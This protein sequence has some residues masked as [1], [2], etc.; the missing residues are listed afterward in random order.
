M[1]NKKIVAIVFLL[2][3]SFSIMSPIMVYADDGNSKDP[4]YVNIFIVLFDNILSPFFGISEPADHVFKSHLN[5]DENRENCQ[6]KYWGIYDYEEFNN[7]IF[8]GYTI[9]SVVIGSLFVGAL[10]KTFIQFS[11][12]PLSSTLKLNVIDV[13]LRTFIALLLILNFFAIIGMLFEL[14]A[15]G[16]SLLDR[17]I[18]M[19][20]NLSAYGADLVGS[21]T[22]AGDRITVTDLAN[23][24]N[25]FKRLI[26]NFF[27]L[28]IA[29]WFEAF[30]LM[31]I[32][33]ISMLIILAPIWIGTMFFPMLKGITGAAMKE[34]WAQIISQF[35]HAALFWLFFWLF[36]SK[37][38]SWF[39]MVLALAMFIPIAEAIRFVLGATSQNAGRIATVATLAGAGALFHG[40]RA[41]KDVSS[42]IKEG[43]SMMR[44]SRNG[45]GH[46][47]EG[48][49]RNSAQGGAMSQRHRQSA[50]YSMQQVQP[51]NAHQNKMQA[52]GAMV[53]GLGR[54]LGRFGG[55][56]SGIG[57]GPMGQY[58]M[59]EMGAGAGDAAGY[60][61]GTAAYGVG[62]RAASKT[63]DAYE[64]RKQGNDNMKFMQKVRAGMASGV[65][66]AKRT[67]APSKQFFSDPVYRR[68]ALQQ[69]GGG[70]GEVVFG[71]GGYDIGSDFAGNRAKGI[72][73]SS[74]S[75]KH[76]EQIYTIETQDGSWLAR[77][78]SE[79]GYQRVSNV[80][81]GNVS[82][83]KGQQAIKEYVV[84]KKDGVF[85]LSPTTITQQADGQNT[86]IEKPAYSYDSEGRKV[87]Y[88]NKTVN[89]MDFIERKPLN[90]VDI[91][92]Q[93]AVHKRDFTGDLR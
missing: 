54:G 4:W 56:M 42:G 75:F 84:D 51:E 50:N 11:F 32:F 81:R 46:E 70:T 38:I 74:G 17:D 63:K 1:K 18:R 14:N 6:P 25:G 76:E 78:S 62:S 83:E 53:S 27:S 71:R 60:R 13:G 66:G 92:R 33:M 90:H 79:G 82:L 69:F 2:V 87:I 3:I 57:L 91:R 23:D 8:R 52:A 15:V 20:L 40:A 16:V 47:R 93:Q 67:V 29:I 61:S 12:S 55:S 26:V 68:S 28:G 10:V 21:Y 58:A 5:C 80:G 34:L 41:V 31:R 49:Q 30:Y 9:F 22:S 86:V 89:P 19:P 48:A 72:T 77:Q 73:S 64:E 7:A 85:R 39:Q 88:E 45:N 24:M 44:G 35:I 43:S 36:K 37:E 65:A 59:A